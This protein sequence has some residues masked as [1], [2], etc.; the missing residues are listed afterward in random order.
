MFDQWSLPLGIG[1]VVCLTVITLFVCFWFKQRMGWLMHI[2]AIGLAG[3]ML[4]G[5]QQNLRRSSQTDI[6]HC[7]GMVDISQSM[8]QTDGKEH[9]RLQQLQQDVLNTQ[10]I[11]PN[12]SDMKWNWST[13]G[14]QPAFTS[15]DSLSALTPEDQATNLLQTL[16]QLDQQLPKDQ[17][18]IVFSDGNST[19]TRQTLTV[20]DQLKNN[21][22]VVHAFAVGKPAT[23]PEIKAF[24]WAQP[25]VIQKDTQTTLYAQLH[26]LSSLDGVSDITA[27]LYDQQ[28]IIAETTQTSD[29]LNAMQFDF[30][31]TDLDVGLHVYRIQITDA[32]SREMATATASVNVLDQPIKVFLLESSPHWVS[33]NAARAIQMDPH[34]QFTARYGL[35]ERRQLQIGQ[36]KQQISDHDIAMDQWD[37]LLLGKD[38]QTQLDEQAREHLA[39]WVDQGGGL[40]WLRGLPENQRDWPARLI[41]NTVMPSETVNALLADL[42]LPIEVRQQLA[43]KIKRTASGGQV[44]AIDLDALNLPAIQSPAMDQLILRLVN[45]LAKPMSVETGSWARMTLDRHAAVM[46]EQVHINVLVLDQQQPMLQVTLPDGETLTVTLTADTANPLHYTVTYE[47]TQTGAYVFHLASHTLPAQAMHVRP[48]GMESQHLAANHGLLQLITEQTGGHLWHDHEQMINDLKLDHQRRLAPQPTRV[49][50]DR[51][52]HP[53]LVILLLSLWLGGWYLNRRK[54]G[55]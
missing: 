54:G 41:P 28:T 32:Q 2:L 11:H 13:F 36:A 51:F 23:Q 22:R 29:S 38:T 33:R 4:M 21:H 12:I 55:V 9:T 53:A 26:G 48:V 5:P 50:Q 27:K 10:A 39:K 17:P 49:W 31:L 44:W 46:D 14:N 7:H 15:L 40:L 42:N 37:V 20:I 6:T 25:S 52:N 35:G 18:I 30:P 3:L 45:R 34:I 16:S 19:E 43:I 47:P 24:A 1:A 8:A